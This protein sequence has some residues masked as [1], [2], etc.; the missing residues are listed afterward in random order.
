MFVVFIAFWGAERWGGAAAVGIGCGA[1]L[2]L[3]F[4]LLVFTLWSW[5]AQAD[6]AREEAGVW[7]AAR[8]SL[9]VLGRRLGA[10]LLVFLLVFL[11]GMVTSFGASMLSILLPGVAGDGLAV[12]IGGL[13]IVTLL[14]WIAGGI[15]SIALGGTLVALIRHELIREAAITA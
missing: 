5:L 11:A 8:H 9:E 13:A 1:A 15:L 2:P 4:G 10:V 6:A 7:M 12:Q 3:T 14:Q